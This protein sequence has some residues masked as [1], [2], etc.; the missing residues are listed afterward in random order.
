M[1]LPMKDLQKIAGKALTSFLRSS[2][3]ARWEFDDLRQEALTT[4]VAASGTYDPEKAKGT[5]EALWVTYR[6]NDALKNY[7]VRK[8]QKHYTTPPNDYASPYWSIHE[9]V[10]VEQ[11]PEE[12]EQED[13]IVE[14][15]SGIEFTS[16]QQIV[17]RYYLEDGTHSRATAK[18]GLAH[19][20]VSQIWRDIV[21]KIQKANGLEILQDSLDP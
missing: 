17:L 21:R 5:S 18:L 20:R 4:A 19:Q 14:L 2:P 6:V 10:D 12:T 13:L 7:M 1:A 16:N 8:V 3:Y 15:L 11:I 9:P